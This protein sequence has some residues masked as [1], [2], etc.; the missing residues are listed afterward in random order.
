MSQQDLDG[1]EIRTALEQVGRKRVPEHVWAQSRTDARLYAI[2]LQE[3][4]DAHS[5]QCVAAARVD[6]YAQRGAAAEQRLARSP[7]VF[8]EPRHGLVADWHEAF[9][10]TL[11]LRR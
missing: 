5:C 7:Q 4:P 9:L 10:G 2:G 3:L 6:E 11:T 1:P 8:R